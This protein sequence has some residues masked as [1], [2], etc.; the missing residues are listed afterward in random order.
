LEA[1]RRIFP[2][3][4]FWGRGLFKLTVRPASQRS[5]A[6]KAGRV[7]LSIIGAGFDAGQSSFGNR[8]FESR[9]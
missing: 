8:Y 6:K 5:H 2:K 7:E 9:N 3:V 1:L 4:R